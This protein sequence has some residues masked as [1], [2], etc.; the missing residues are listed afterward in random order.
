MLAA[1]DR[2]DEA[3]VARR[4][5][6][7]DGEFPSANDRV[8]AATALE[9][10]TRLLW[11]LGRVEDCVASAERA[12]RLRPDE[13]GGRIQFPARVS[14]RRRGGGRSSA[15]AWRR[16]I[17]RSRYL[18]PRILIGGLVDPARSAEA[19][20]SPGASTTAGGG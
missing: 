17:V 10:R 5:G 4:A 18:G 1:L 2:A 6:E 11:R 13:S 15:H 7:A 12:T 20:A 3:V 19:L 9:R 16:S 8:Y 14:R